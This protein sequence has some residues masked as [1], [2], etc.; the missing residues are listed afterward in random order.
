MRKAPSAVNSRA[1]ASASARQRRTR[2]SIRASRNRTPV[3]AG[4][5]SSRPSS[6]NAALIV[7]APAWVQKNSAL[8]RSADARS[9][10]SNQARAPMPTKAR[11]TGQAAPAWNGSI[12]AS[13]APNS[14][15]SAP[16]AGPTMGSSWATLRSIPAS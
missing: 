4:S 2:G 14:S 3:N 11:R 16:K 15:T 1:G 6:S 9:G 7:I 13:H 5:A 12:H 8:R 10:R